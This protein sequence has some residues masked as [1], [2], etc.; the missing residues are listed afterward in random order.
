MRVLLLLTAFALHGSLL[1]QP[2]SL[3]VTFSGDGI[4][5]TDVGGGA[6]Y[7][8]AYAVAVQPDGAILVAGTSG[9]ESAWDFGVVRYL[10]DGTPDQA[11][12]NG[13]RVT[14]PVGLGDDVARAVVVRPDGR[15]LLGGYTYTDQGIAFAL[16]RLNADG[17]LDQGFGTDGHVI[18]VTPVDVTLQARTMALQP[19][20][21][22]IL[23]GGGSA[24][25][26][27]MRYTESGIP[28]STFD[29]DGLVTIH[30]SNGNDQCTALAVQ[31][32]SRI[33]L[34]G[35]SNGLQSDSVAMARLEPDGTLDDTFGNGGIV[36]ANYPGLPSAA[37]GLD[38]MND[39]RFV[40]C[41]SANTRAIAA[42][43]HPDG[44][45]DESFNG[46][47]WKF[48]TFAGTTL[49]RFNGVHVQEDGSIVLGGTVNSNVADLL[50]VHLR[51]DGTF[52]DAFGS[53]GTTI[54]DIE[55]LEDDANAMAVQTDGRIL[56]AGGT[57]GGT[58]DFDFAVARYLPDLTL[59]VAKEEA[60]EQGS[61][62]YPVPMG[63]LL[64]IEYMLKAE[65]RVTLD[66]VGS[67]G[68]I[69]SRMLDGASRGPGAH[70]ESFDMF[71]TP[72]PGAYVLRLSSGS[73]RAERLLVR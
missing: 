14:A 38:L 8:Q 7:D 9:Y 56:L 70:K 69:I 58:S 45:A 19:D 73:F 33:L 52:N 27:I 2:G 32:D 61:F 3:D 72:D 68:R 48:F 1:A 23:A 18:T 4:Q 10:M 65:E 55:G 6:T 31:P 57:N 26:A 24:G 30:F 16:V 37:L 5:T 71:K 13:G 17:S 42:R 25:F 59:A 53:G 34:V 43:F 62:V 11:F 50:L 66:L 47:G 28:D 39:G 46:F 51:A 22:I 15:I 67:D 41:G 54:T 49:A 36:R 63:D 35:Y 21:R 40:I 64:T 60:L 29:D 44:T 12:G 20:G